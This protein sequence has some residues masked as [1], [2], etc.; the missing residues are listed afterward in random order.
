MAKIRDSAVT[1]FATATTS[2]V[3]QM[4]T[5]AIG[6]L[7]LA[8]VS[9]DL[10]AAFTTP[11]TWTLV[12]AAA[13]AAA[14]S[15][16]G[17]YAKIATT[18]SET[19]SFALA[20]ATCMAT[21]VSVKQ[22]LGSSVATAVSASSISAGD[23]T[24]PFGGGTLA[25]ANTNCLVFASLYSNVGIGPGPEPGW[26]NIFSGDTGANS[27]GLAY[28]FQPTSTTVTGPNWYGALND[29]T[30]AVLIAIRDDG[31]L[32]EKD[33]YVPAGTTPAAILSPLVGVS[34]LDLGTWI[35]GNA[36]IF[37]TIAG[38]A[39]T[40]ATGLTI[41]ATLDAG[42]NPFRSAS[43]T[44]GVSSTTGLAHTEFTPTTAYNLTL[45]KGIL[46]GT[47]RPS[48]PRDYVDLGS[49]ADG[50]VYFVIGTA[51]T[52]HKTWRVGGQF[53]ATTKAD[54]RNNWAIQVGQTANTAYSTGAGGAPTL[55]AISRI[56][57]GS[58]G[59][60][61]APSIQW[62][63]LYLL[64]EVVLAGGTA[65]FPFGFTEFVQT[66]NGGSGNI[67]LIQ[68]SGSAGTLW[69]PI[70]FG[71]TDP[72]H[73]SL[74]LVTLQYPK[75]SDNIDYAEWHVD[76]EYVGI[77]LYGLTG[78]TLKFRNCLFTSESPYYFRFNALHQS[79]ATVDLSGSSIVKALV[80]LSANAA[81]SDVTF[82]TCAEIAQAGNTITS[83][84]FTSTRATATQGAVLITGAT[85]GA[86]QTALSNFV[87]CTFTNNTSSNAAID[88]VYTGTAGPITLSMTSGTFSG[89]SKDIRWDAPASSNLTINLSGTANPSTSFA[90]NGNV[91]TLASTKTF[92][93][94]NIE[95]NTEL[96]LYKKSDNS[97][98]ASVEDIGNTT[99][100]AIN[101][102]TA[103]DT[104][105]T[106]K[107]KATYS[108][109][110]A[111]LGVDTPVFVV[112]HSL[113]YQWLRQTA[114]L[115]NT[116]SEFKISQIVDRQYQNP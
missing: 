43:T 21:L 70:R 84:T 9:K 60:Y 97:F 33:A 98:L 83:C 115:K 25:T 24:S 86:L 35:A 12:Q 15:Y 67:P 53:S 18:A 28:R 80:T 6:D 3:C 91:V 23:A 90:T 39:T 78:D 37:A 14:T 54:A 51:A 79:G 116:D 88:I 74:N 72:C 106:G 50:G 46:F 26:V 107:Y 64:N 49:I 65:A 29:A 47:F 59:Y 55:S 30:K 99:P 58:S 27:L 40:S 5:H 93:V 95:A 31:N 13:D 56:A 63:E 76:D 77:E 36:R 112:A 109:N 41:S 85:Q 8:F 2:M 17:V 48:I 81:I 113:G 69:A 68:V 32:S 94:T 10:S 71:G 62:N 45:Q 87:N 73:V 102:V 75:K 61:G 82:N 42:Y 52:V 34:A 44:A 7:I 92:T 1:I 101:F 16:G 103:N 110:Y 89:N 104:E 108:Y 96:V 19:V 22:V 100:G 105:N 38:K 57:V 66:V 20:S 111:L 4:P 114:T 11:A